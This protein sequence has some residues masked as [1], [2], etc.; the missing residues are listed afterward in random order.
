MRDKNFLI[1]NNAKPIWHPMA[2]PAEMRGNP[3]RVIMKGE[4]AYV[5]DI[6]GRTVLDAVGGLWNVNLGYSCDPI[7][8]A[9]AAQL[10]ALPYYSGFRG[11]STGPSIELAY[12]LTQFFAP[13]GMVRAF[14]TSG[15]SDSVE[16]ALRLARQYWKIRGQGD[17]TKFIALKKGYHG[18]H[19]GGASVNGNA[20][21]RRNYEPL[22]PGVFHIPAP[23]TYRNPFDETDPERL[24]RLCAK[25]LED[26]IA[27]QGADTIAAFIM[28]PILGAGGVIVP[29]ESFMRLARDIC[30]RHE[31]LFIADEVVTGFGRAGAWSGSRLHG[32]KPDMMTIAK[33]I[34]C[35]Y[36]P[37]GATLIGEEVA[38]V[39]EADRTSF[40]AIGH[41]YTYSGHPVGCA[42]G[43]AALVE[44]RRLKVDENAAARGRELADVLE[45]LKRKH[46]LI[47]DIR[48]K[49]LMAA[50]ELVS[51]REMKRPADKATMA[52]VADA[53]YEA[54]VMLRISGSNIILSPPLI[55]KTEEVRMIGEA[56]DA[57]LM[58]AS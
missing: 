8:R 48:C 3:P 27:F 54:G 29:H 1:E 24:A 9:I 7:K 52:K 47:G 25:S 15:G 51:D 21:F 16:T 53:A 2:H 31:I 4:G 35:G 45:G 50:L 44:T 14:F 13:E 26:E 39:F 22:M 10:D 42:A 57:G 30:N 37:L 11:T 43:L 58:Q 33:A 23:Y 6:E 55:L 38:E 40:G 17:R 49:G 34:T 46:A 32:V 5:T 36:F 19:F 28:E 18:T 56:L 12:E 41:G 20:N